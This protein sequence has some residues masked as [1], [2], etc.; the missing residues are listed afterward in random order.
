KARDQN[1]RVFVGGARNREN[2]VERHGNVSD[3]NLQ[4][5]LTQG[6]LRAIATRDRTVGVEVSILERFF[7]VLDIVVRNAQLAPHLPAYP[8]QENAAGKQQAYDLQELGGDERKAD[9]HQRCC[10]NTDKDRL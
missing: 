2:V 4:D 10:E 6:L 5:G 7:G 3:Q 8:E 9:A 1:P